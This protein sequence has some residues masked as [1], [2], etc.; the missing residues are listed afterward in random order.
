MLEIFAKE[1]EGAL[2]RETQP[3]RQ[4]SLKIPLGGRLATVRVSL[5]DYEEAASPSSDRP[6]R[7]PLLSD[8]A[9]ARSYETM[10]SRLDESVTLGDVAS[11]IGLSPWQ[12]SRAFHNST[13]IGFRACLRGMRIERAMSRMLESDEPLCDVA[14]ASG[15]ADQ[16]TFSRVFLRATGFTPSEWRRSQR[17]TT[18][19]PLPSPDRG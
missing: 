10:R 9:I 3:G 5:E 18:R 8:R 1:L 2:A 4:V 11:A 6:R 14:L 17:L 12:F 16:S 15:F 7:G 19:P 13:G